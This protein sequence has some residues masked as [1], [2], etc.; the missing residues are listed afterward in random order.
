MILQNHAKSLHVH[1][2][3][4]EQGGRLHNRLYFLKRAYM[5]FFLQVVVKLWVGVYLK[6]EDSTLKG[7]V[8]WSFLAEHIHCHTKRFPIDS[9]IKVAH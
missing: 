5:Q 1:G 2:Q 7:N 6:K 4:G 3:P 8:C 9:K